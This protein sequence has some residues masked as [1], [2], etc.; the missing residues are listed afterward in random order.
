MGLKD[1]RHPGRLEMRAGGG[2]QPA[3]LFDGAHNP[4][5]AF[6]LRSY[7]IE[8]MSPPPPLTILFAAMSDKD[9]VQ[10]TNTLFPLAHRI[11]LSEIPNSPRAAKIS[12]LKH[13]AL[14]HLNESCIAEALSPEEAWRKAQAL[15]ELE[16]IICVTG[17]LYLIGEIQSLLELQK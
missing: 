2:S 1:T 13:L 12:V 15:T 9:L 5:G 14:Q 10:I 3:V 8:F 11:V 16:G 7:L 6:A 17:S 4:A